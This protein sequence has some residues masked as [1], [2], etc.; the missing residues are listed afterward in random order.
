MKAKVDYHVQNYD[1]NVVSF[2][3]MTYRKLAPK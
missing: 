1:V 2:G 3:G